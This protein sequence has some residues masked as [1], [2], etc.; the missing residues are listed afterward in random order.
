MITW[1]LPCMKTVLAIIIN[2]ILFSENH[3]IYY[4]IPSDVEVE[5]ICIPIPHHGV[6]NSLNDFD[7]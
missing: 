5:N 4:L 3:I 1:I 7:G 2:T 6:Q